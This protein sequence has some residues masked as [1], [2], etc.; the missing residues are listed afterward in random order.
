MQGHPR[1]THSNVKV[2]I[3]KFVEFRALFSTTFRQTFALETWEISCRLS[4]I[5][6]GLTKFYQIFA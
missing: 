3:A 2:M 1:V 6:K 4:E 5:F